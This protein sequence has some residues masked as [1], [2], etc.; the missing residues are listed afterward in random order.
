MQT[1]PDAVGKHIP[2][3][4]LSLNASSK[5]VSKLFLNKFHKSHKKSDQA[6]IS[7]E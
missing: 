1:L 7:T 5:Y 2:L 6:D 3:L 4:P